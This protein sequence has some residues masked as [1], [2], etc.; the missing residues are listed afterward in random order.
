[1]AETEPPQGG[2]VDTIHADPFVAAAILGGTTL[3]AWKAGEYVGNL[4]ELAPLPAALGLTAAAM[5]AAP[6]KW[7]P[8]PLHTAVCTGLL[9]STVAPCPTITEAQAVALASTAVS[10]YVPNA[11]T[12]SDAGSATIVGITSLAAL[13]GAIVNDT[14]GA[15]SVSP[16][17]FLGAWALGH[18]AFLQ[19]AR[20]RADEVATGMVVSAA[21]LTTLISRA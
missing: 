4:T 18:V 14:V 3:L 6:G 13:A 2:T 12:I 15:G 9:T 1:M 19:R 7:F 11:V 5:G 21:V 17:V 10:N 16:R 8:P 20:G